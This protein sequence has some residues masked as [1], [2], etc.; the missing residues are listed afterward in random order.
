LCGD[1]RQGYRFIGVEG[2][3][4]LQVFQQSTHP[5]DIL[6][7]RWKRKSIVGGKLESKKL[8]EFDAGRLVNVLEAQTN[9][10]TL[11]E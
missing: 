6:S 4:R 10:G 7:N 9:T 1:R 3:F 5:Y 8:I 2:T 11:Y